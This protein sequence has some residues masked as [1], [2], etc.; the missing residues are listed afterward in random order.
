M[1]DTTSEQE[2]SAELWDQGQCD[3]LTSY[4]KGNRRYQMLGSSG[5]TL[6]K[7]FLCLSFWFPNKELRDEKDPKKVSLILGAYFQDAP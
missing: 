3:Q 6:N 4:R 5:T 7:I 1:P 2:D